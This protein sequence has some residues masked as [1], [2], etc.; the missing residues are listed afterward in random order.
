MSDLFG[1]EM[2]GDVPDNGFIPE[3]FEDV[4][5]PLMLR[6]L[7]ALIE[8]CA[9]LHFVGVLEVNTIA[10]VTGIVLLAMEAVDFGYRMYKT[11]KG[12]NVC[13]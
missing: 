12:A 6:V 7:V 9:I 10:Y 2:G 13:Q 1:R 4:G 3:E 5:V 11:Y 8:F